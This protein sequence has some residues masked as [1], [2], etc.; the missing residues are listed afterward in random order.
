MKKS[1]FLSL[2]V[3]AAV[4]V[5]CKGGKNNPSVVT[6]ISL[7]P[8]EAVLIEGD[9]VNL[10]LLWE[11]ATAAQ[12]TDLVWE[13]SDTTVVQF[14]D[15]N[16]TIAARNAGEANVT[17]TSGE[18][19]ASA[20][21]T[22]MMFED[23]YELDWL[24]Y[25]PSTKE[26][27][28]DSVYKMTSASGNVYDCKLYNVTFVA[29]NKL[30]FTEDFVGEGYCIW[31]DA[32]VLFVE[33]GEA[34][35]EMWER[36]LVL[37]DD[38]SKLAVEPFACLAGSFDPEIVGSVFQPYLEDETGSVSL[39]WDLYETGV[40]GAIIA[41]VESDDEGVG[42]YMPYY[43]KLNSGELKLVSDEEGNRSLAYDFT[44]NWFYGWYG[45]AVNYDAESY[46]DLL[47]QPFETSFSDEYRYRH[48]A[49]AEIMGAP[50]RRMRAAKHSNN[51]KVL[52]ERIAERPVKVK[53]V[54]D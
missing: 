42:R 25:F 48:D 36:K 53:F 24:Y 29:P 16:G 38:E 17:V 1:L 34:D 51:P 4:L 46:A 23:A 28:S 43:G 8:S 47:L 26:L 40:K 41:D 13:S 45:L 39:N 19:K 2:V 52:V 6:S 50:Q 35:G 12:P 27:L 9:T 33:G 15:L 3:V 21:I 20:R 31:C 7:K 22:V 37:T 5:G 14:V 18:L 32:S 54:K 49:P 44:M 11:P 10:A 30:Q